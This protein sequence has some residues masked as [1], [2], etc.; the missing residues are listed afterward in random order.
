MYP[1]L[2]WEKVRPKVQELFQQELNRL[3]PLRVPM[4]L[5]KRPSGRLALVF[6]SQPPEAKRALQ[7]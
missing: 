1:F 4:L 3:Q 2:A 6:P 7:S 5:V